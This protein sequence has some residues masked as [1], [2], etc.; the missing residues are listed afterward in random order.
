MQAAAAANGGT[1]EKRSRN[2]EENPAASTAYRLDADQDKAKN[3]SSAPQHEESKRSI[4]APK[5]S[6]SKN[7]HIQATTLFD[8]QS[9]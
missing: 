2:D 1:S 3:P 5:L 9:D 4:E 8:K 7:P 6:Q